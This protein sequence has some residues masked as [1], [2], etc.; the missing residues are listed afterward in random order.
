MC[1]GLAPVASRRN[2]SRRRAASGVIAGQA[3]DLLARC[4]GSRRCNGAAG[5]IVVNVPPPGWDRV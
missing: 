3:G 2:A 4:W 5:V 1:S